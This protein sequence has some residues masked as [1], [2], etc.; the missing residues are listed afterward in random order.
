M[1]QAAAEFERLICRIAQLARAT[2]IHLI[3]ATQRPSVNVITGVIKAN[4]SSRIAFAVASQVDSRTILDG[5]GAERL[6]GQGDMLF[7]PIDAVKPVRIQGTYLSEEEVN[8]VVEILNQ[9]GGAPTEYALDLNQVE[10]QMQAEARAKATA[11][12]RDPLF[13]DAVSL[14]RRR[15]TASASMLQREFEIGYPRA[16]RLMD[17]LEKAGIIGPQE[18]SKPREI[19]VGPLM[20]GE[21]EMSSVQQEEEIS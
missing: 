10:E 11:E 18:G 6:I 14:V 21:R 2:G 9:W 13:D 3:I 16:G 4:I 15:G 17:Q 12:E 7:H 8:R 19:L 20:D 5:N 1:M